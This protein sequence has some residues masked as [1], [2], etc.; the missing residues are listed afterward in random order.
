MSKTI[1]QRLQQSRVS[2]PKHTLQ[3]ENRPAS[4]L[5]RHEPLPITTGQTA[6][7]RRAGT[8]VF[9]RQDRTS[10]KALK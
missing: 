6:P 8:G 5:A 4:A 7:A 1:G 10:L 3:W 9:F 2:D